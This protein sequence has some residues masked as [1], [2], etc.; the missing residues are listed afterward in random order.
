MELYPLRFTPIFKER[1]WGGNKL[2]EILKKEVIGPRIGESWEISTVN[3]NVSEVA[4]GVLV[5]RSLTSL[6]QEFGPRLVGGKV[7]KQF[8]DDF[9]LLIKFIDAE[10]DLSIQLHPNDELAKKRHNSF[11]KTEMWHIMQAEK[12]ARLI[13]GF[14]R[15]VTKEEYQQ[16][17][18][19]KRLTELLHYEEVVSGD[20]FFI[21]TGTIHAIGA[22]I[23]LAEIQQT[24][25]ITYRVYD[26]DRKDKDG[27]PREL[28]TELALDA[29]DL[30]G[31]QD[32]KVHYHKDVNSTNAMVQCPY[33]TTDY[34]SVKGEVILDHTVKDSF[35]IYLC[36][37]G[38]AALQVHG[39]RYGISKGET[40][41]VPAE[42]KKMVLQATD[43]KLLQVYI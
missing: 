38:S 42:L 31:R 14:S 19:D 15:E 1:L 23:L 20:T 22:G 8:R 10:K 18:N 28:H 40:L 5:G 21:E 11:G 33:F 4:N 36:V 9:P 30:K 27:K 3:N 7:H 26:F 24:S 6:I 12:G 37:S 16:H 41:L 17:L 32:H 43:A 29:I 13:M 25:D 35:F 39:E 34:I 2:R